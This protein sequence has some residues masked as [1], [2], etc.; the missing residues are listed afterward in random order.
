MR[1]RK[2]KH[3]NTPLWGVAYIYVFIF[4]GD[5]WEPPFIMKGAKIHNS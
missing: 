3:M 2:K 5:G 1:L 4:R